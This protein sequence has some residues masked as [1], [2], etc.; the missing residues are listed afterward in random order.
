MANL[1]STNYARDDGRE[2]LSAIARLASSTLRWIDSLDIDRAAAEEAKVRLI[3][4]I[5]GGQVDVT[6]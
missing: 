1:A 2:V 4:T 5:A 3:I 6:I